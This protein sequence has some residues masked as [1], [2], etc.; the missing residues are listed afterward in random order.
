LPHPCPITLSLTLQ[1]EVIQAIIEPLDFFLLTRDYLQYF[2]SVPQ[3]YRLLDNEAKPAIV[4]LT[5][6]V[7][8]T[9]LLEALEEDLLTQVY[10]VASH[11]TVNDLKVIFFTSKC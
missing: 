2:H 1:H 7:A 10:S 4:N 3:R 9:V 11:A 8:A 6:P 5:K